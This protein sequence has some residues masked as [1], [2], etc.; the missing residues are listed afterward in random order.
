MGTLFK[1]IPLTRV[2]QQ[3][4]LPWMLLW[5]VLLA[6]ALFTLFRID[7]VFFGTAFLIVLLALANRAFASVKL[8][9]GQRPFAFVTAVKGFS[10]ATSILLATGLSYPF[11]RQGSSYTRFVS[12]SADGDRTP[13]TPPTEDSD[14]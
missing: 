7:V 13:E 1:D 5:W 11:F 10:L 4:L 14:E 6:G 3:L 12:T 2:A 9:D 8:P